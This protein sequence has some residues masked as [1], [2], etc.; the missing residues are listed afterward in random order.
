MWHICSLG[1]ESNIFP[2]GPVGV[3]RRSYVF[4][5]GQGG[6]GKSTLLFN[7]V[8]DYARRA[9]GLINVLV[10]DLSQSFDTTRRFLGDSG[11][12]QSKLQRGARD[13][14]TVQTF[15]FNAASY[16]G[17]GDNP[18]Q[19]WFS[20]PADRFV[21]VNTANPRFP[22]KNVYLLPANHNLHTMSRADLAGLIPPAKVGL[23]AQAVIEGARQSGQHWAIFINTDAVN[24]QPESKPLLRLA[25]N[26]AEKATIVMT[27]DDASWFAT[28]TLMRRLADMGEK[29]A[30]VTG[31]LVNRIPVS[32]ED[33]ASRHAILIRLNLICVFGDGSTRT[34]NAARDH[35]TRPTAA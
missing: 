32:R 29:R 24:E 26:L 5:S 7:V 15:L 12:G 6:A 27:L 3:G 21:H 8:A 35:L 10:M 18:L 28:E 34:S 33:L 23:M 17:Q 25:L 19:G 9:N 4:L 1:R 30:F 16:T 20:R 31:F 22:D 11:V 13:P 14:T 2:T